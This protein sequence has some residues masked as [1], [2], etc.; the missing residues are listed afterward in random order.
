MKVFFY[1]QVFH[2]TKYSQSKIL[3]QKWTLSHVWLFA[4]PWTTVHVILQARIL[5]WVAIPFSRDLH[6]PGIKP[7]S[8]TLQPDSLPA[9]PQLPQG[10]YKIQSAASK[11]NTQV[12]NK[13]RYGLYNPSWHVQKYLLWWYIL[14]LLYCID[15]FPSILWWKYIQNFYESKWHC[16][17]VL[18]S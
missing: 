16:L 15:E 6:N 10:K 11:R 18:N 1:P 7:R 5:E 14:K 4:T 2:L 12:Q 9:E 3:P 17:T 8:P 13:V